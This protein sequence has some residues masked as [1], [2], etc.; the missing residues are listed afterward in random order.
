MKKCN[1]CGLEKDES[2]FF[3][4]KSKKDGLTSFCKVCK[5][6]YD[7]KYRASHADKLSE[8]GK[9]YRA[10]H[11]DELLKYHKKYREINKDTLLQQNREYQRVRRKTNKDKLYCFKTPCV[12]CGDSRPYVIDFHHI[13]PSTKSFNVSTMGSRHTTVE[14]S[15]EVKKCVCLC[16][17]CHQE[18]HYFFGNKPE[19]PVESLEEY[20]GKAIIEG[21]DE[22]D[23]NR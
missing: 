23:S 17:N 3:R 19:K 20:L 16:R 12:K 11:S 5:K 10:E 15:E 6:A 4:D 8:Y 7:I 18:Y 1:C 22:N 13:D 21:S 2:E 9:K 14:I